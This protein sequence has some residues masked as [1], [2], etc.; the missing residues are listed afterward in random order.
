MAPSTKHARVLLVDDDVRA[1]RALARMLRDEGF[2]IDL[3]PDGV[4]AIARISR[5]TPDVLVVGTQ[6][7]HVSGFAVAQFA[8][9]RRPD[10]PIL[11]MSGEPE[12]AGDHE[13]S[14]APRAR[15]LSKPVTYEALSAAIRWAEATLTPAA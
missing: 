11:L 9:S 10:A 2:D 13:R 5:E 12:L 1:V 6:L 14:L 3:A 15:V 8:R 4:A 7:P